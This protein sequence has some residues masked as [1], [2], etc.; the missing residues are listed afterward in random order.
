M[1][2][3]AH[4]EINVSDINIS[5]KF[6]ELILENLG[7]KS[8]ESNKIGSAGFCAPDKTHLYLIQT[9]DKYLDNMFHRK[10]VGLNH[11]AFRVDSKDIIEKL[12]QILKEKNIDM[13][14]HPSSKDYAKEYG[15]QE[16]FAIF[17]EDP[18]RIKI[19]VVF[20]K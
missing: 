5:R 17:F 8:L 4:I 16:Y 14:Y 9:G 3:L 2:A 6:Y 1:N 12:I 10:K 18:D 15:T 13:L 11:I 20:I 7:W 19:E